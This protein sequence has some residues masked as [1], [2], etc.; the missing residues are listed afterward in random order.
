MRHSWFLFFLLIRRLPR[1]T[2]FPYTTLF[3]SLA[4]I[5]QYSLQNFFCFRSLPV[6]A[7]WMSALD[8]NRPFW[9]EHD[10]SRAFTYNHS[11]FLFADCLHWRRRTKQTPS[12]IR[13][14]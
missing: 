9:C 7:P 8:R 2:L 5:T 4:E 11:T 10:C 13:V 14:P 12:P 6:T 3:R 1:S